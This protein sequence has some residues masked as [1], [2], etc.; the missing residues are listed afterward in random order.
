MR[1]T[2]Q[3][4]ENTAAELR[5]SLAE[6][7]TLCE[8][9]A[10]QLASLQSEL[11]TQIAQVETLTQRASTL[12]SKLDAA[13]K[14]HARATEQHKESV[15]LGEEALKSKRDAA[16]QHAQALERKEVEL[17]AQRKQLTEHAATIESLTRAVAQLEATCDELQQRVADGNNNAGGGD[18][19]SNA[20]DGGGEDAVALAKQVERQRQLLA[21]QDH[22][23]RA[24]GIAV[25]TQTA[26]LASLEAA[27]HKEAE[28]V[29]ALRQELADAKEMSESVAGDGEGSGSGALEALQAQV[30]ANEETRRAQ[31]AEL[32]QLREA[33]ASAEASARE[34]SV[35]EVRVCL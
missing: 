21:T 17:A 19:E 34:P 12:E 13:N 29:R 25:L 5:A 14:Q 3:Q 4:A 24:K 32:K 30:R 27:H 15:S 31:E 22:E 33:L 16:L 18:A 35:V 10:T 23:L 6:K 7:Q 2:Q 28:K 11:A 9:Q 8:A 1:A 26:R 20:V